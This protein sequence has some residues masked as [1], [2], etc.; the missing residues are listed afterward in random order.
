MTTSY[1]IVSDGG[2]YVQRGNELEAYLEPQSEIP[3]FEL[4]SM[5]VDWR[6]LPQN[7]MFELLTFS[8]KVE[9]ANRMI[10]GVNEYQATPPDFDEFFQE[11]RYQ[12][13]TL[14]LKAADLAA[15]LRKL[16]KLPKHEYGA[17]LWDPIADML[18]ERNE[19][20]AI[21]E[22]HRVIQ[23]E[24]AKQFVVNRAETNS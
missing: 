8:S 2:R 10:E 5:D 14:G 1:A 6:C 21:R 7:L 15:E 13:A 9:Q 22:Q 11:R 17:E 3:I 18:K 24:S 20:E 16:S 23:Q 12:Y 4:S 19:I